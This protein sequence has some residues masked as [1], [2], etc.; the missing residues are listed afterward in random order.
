[1]NFKDSLEKNDYN[2]LSFSKSPCIF[3]MGER[4]SVGGGERGRE[5][6]RERGER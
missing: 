5:S 1:M 3:F 2:T 6:V 4:E